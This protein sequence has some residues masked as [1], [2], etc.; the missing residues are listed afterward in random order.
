MKKALKEKPTT[1]IAKIMAR[2]DKAYK[3][4]FDDD[5]VLAITAMVNGH[6]RPVLLCEPSVEAESVLL[7][8]PEGTSKVFMTFLTRNCGIRKS[9]MN[10]LD[11]QSCRLLL[12]AVY[13]PH[14][15]HFKDE[16]GKTIVGFFSDEP[17]IGNG[18]YFKND[19]TMGSDMDFPWSRTLEEQMPEILGEDWKSLLPFIWDDCGNSA[20]ASQVRYSYMDAVTRIVEECFSRQVGNWCRAHDVSYIGHIIEDGNAH[21]RTANSLGH[22]FRGLSG[23]DMAGIDDIGGQ[24]IPYEED[25]PAGKIAEMFGGRDGEFYHFMLGKLASSMAYIQPEKMGRSMCEIFGNYGWSEGPRMEKYLADHF[26]VRGI[27][28]FVPHAFSPK[29]YPD[30]DC[31][32]HFYANG[33][34]PQYRAFSSVIS[35][36]NRICELVSDGR[37]VL[38]T[39]VLYHAEGEWAGKAMLDQ[40]VTR[41]LMENQID[42][43]VIPTD[44]FEEPKR[45]ETTITENGITVNGNT[46]K[47]FI[48]P[49]TQYITSTL[50]DAITDAID[51]G[52][53]VIFIDSLPDGVVG[54]KSLPECILNNPSNLKIV[55]NDRLVDCLNKEIEVTPVNKRLRSLHY[56]KGDKEIYYFVN[57]DDEIYD[58]EIRIARIESCVGYDAWEDKYCKQNFVNRD[59]YTA[60]KVKLRPSESRIVIVSTNRFET[61]G[62]YLLET[63]EN[64]EVSVEVED[65]WRLSTCKAI[66][67]PKFGQASD[68]EGFFDFGEKNK[69]FSGFLAYDN[70]FS[71]SASD[72]K[73]KIYVIIPDA[74]EDV[75][76]FINSRSAGIQVLPP[77]IYDVTDLLVEGRNEIRVEVATTL[78]REQGVNKKNQAPIGIWSAVEVIK[79]NS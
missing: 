52:V 71:L 55:A 5:R 32:P 23:Q 38:D 50:V 76:L 18:I 51:R 3:T 78:E 54:G 10:T 61:S 47:N 69:K 64:K 35:Y 30:R 58:G 6:D 45:Y 9:Y 75:E 21:A 73:N 44:V 59:E 31:P 72:M 7:Q 14:Y 25:T 63:L 13:E 68:I 34:N 57:E 11:A 79:V 36:M 28:H 66:D 77:F 22:Y 53:Q 43:H 16:F 29:K 1:F 2:T 62:E 19:I 60:L 37:P 12:D 39:A 42:F 33:H 65:K 15:E 56:I 41:E 70:A 48:I 46:Y 24:V 74:G 8:L 17:E 27:N 67:Y 40:K 26:M 20:L 4:F 49:Y